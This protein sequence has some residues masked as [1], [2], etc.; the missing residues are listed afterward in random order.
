MFSVRIRRFHRRYYVCYVVQ[1]GHAI[2]VLADG[3]YCWRW[4]AERNMN[5]ILR[6]MDAA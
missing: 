4:H 1:H 6:K 2:K 3:P 5:F